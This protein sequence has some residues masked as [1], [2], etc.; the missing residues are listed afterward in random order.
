[1]SSSSS[2]PDDSLLS[3]ETTNP[4]GLIAILTPPEGMESDFSDSTKR[5]S[6]PMIVL[7]AVLLAVATLFV[8]NRAWFKWCVV[9]KRGW[10]DWTLGVGFVCLFLWLWV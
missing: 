2:Y 1:M 7:G 5:N 9:R 4:L 6:Q 3:P 10:D 8:G